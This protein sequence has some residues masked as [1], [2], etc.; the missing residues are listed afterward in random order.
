MLSYRICYLFYLKKYLL[1]QKMGSK[2]TKIFLTPKL[3]KYDYFE[4][5][6]FKKKFGNFKQTYP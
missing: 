1:P 3:K 6:P 5:P 4:G 2:K